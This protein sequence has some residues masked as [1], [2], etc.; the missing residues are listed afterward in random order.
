VKQ[1]LNF[2]ILVNPNQE[3]Q[4]FRLMAI[5]PECQMTII[6]AVL[7][8]PELVDGI[9]Q[10]ENGLVS[11][12]SLNYTL[13]SADP[14]H[15]QALIPLRAFQDQVDS[16]IP[17]PVKLPGIKIPGMCSDIVPPNAWINLL[18]GTK[19]MGLEA[20]KTTVTIIVSI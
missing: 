20:I 5:P 9:P 15:A 3:F 11:L 10:G 2:T 7:E 16:E 6:G 17:G 13:T 1:L 12:V 4:W 8:M 19:N 14:S 18:I